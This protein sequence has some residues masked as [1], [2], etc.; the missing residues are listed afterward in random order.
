MHDLPF[1]VFGG[2]ERRRPHIDG[3]NGILSADLCLGS[4]N[5][6]KACK[7]RSYVALDGLSLNHLPISE[8]RC[9]VVNN[10]GD[11]LPST[12]EGA[13]GV[14]EGYVLSVGV[15]LLDG[16]RISFHKLTPAPESIAG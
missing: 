5:R 4:L 7:L 14:T 6:D 2:H 15:T 16:F 9:G 3:S 13:K 10:S 11:L 12:Y 8:L 1:P